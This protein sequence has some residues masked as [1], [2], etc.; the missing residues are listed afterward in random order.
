LPDEAIVALRAV[1]SGKTLV[2]V[3]GIV[4]LGGGLVAGMIG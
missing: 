3:D 1:L 4:N 2:E